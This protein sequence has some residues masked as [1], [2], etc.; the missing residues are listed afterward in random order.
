VLASAGGGA[1]GLVLAGALAAAA[2]ARDSGDMVG[3]L[4][5]AGE[6]RTRGLSGLVAGALTKLVVRECWMPCTMDVLRL[7]A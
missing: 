5:G 3:P 2:S 1:T 7:W 6:A 4:S